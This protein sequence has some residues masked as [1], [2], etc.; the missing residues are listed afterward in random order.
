[1]H[2]IKWSDM[3]PFLQFGV[4]PLD[5]P[6]CLYYQE[7]WLISIR[8]SERDFS[9]VG[10]CLSASMYPVGA[11][12]GVAETIPGHLREGASRSATPWIANW[13]AYKEGNEA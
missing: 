2:P 5:L 13:K 7:V 3:V 1:M 6:T 10:T 8:H 9:C 11:V 12:D 4:R